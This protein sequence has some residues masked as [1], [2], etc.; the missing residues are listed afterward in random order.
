MKL[1]ILGVL[2]L[3]RVIAV[4]AAVKL[5]VE[6]ALT[7]NLAGV[8]AITAFGLALVLLVIPALV[9]YVESEE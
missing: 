6:V 5:G 8:Q 1:L 3:F 9:E 4:F 2:N 7:N